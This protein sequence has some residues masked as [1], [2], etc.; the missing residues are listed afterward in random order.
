MLYEGVTIVLILLGMAFIMFS[1]FISERKIE[2]TPLVDQEEIDLKL[3]ALNNK[4][5]ELNEYSLFMQKELED[6]HKELLFLYQMIND[7]KE[8]LIKTENIG[9]EAN[10]KT[11]H[12]ED[13]KPLNDRKP[14]KNNNEMILDL[15]IQGYQIHEIAR[16]LNIGQG[17]VKLVL[18]LYK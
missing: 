15:S 1:F 17:E 2:E 7:K 16:M 4:I 11:L 5:I 8:Q 6:K 12:L 9:T 3:E 10:D 13:Q 14:H 18:D